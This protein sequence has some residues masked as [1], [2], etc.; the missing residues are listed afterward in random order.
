[1]FFSLMILVVIP[2]FL[3]AFCATAIVHIF[4]MIPYVPSE[5]KV[6][7]KMVQ[8]AR[9]KKNDKVFDLGCGDG[10]LLITAEKKAG[11]QAI[12]FE[13]APLMYLLSKL[14]VLFSRSR[15]QV[16]F[17]SLF[18]APLKSAD[19]I[20]CYLF[21]NAMPR[22][23][24]KIKRECKKGTRVISNTFHIPGLKLIRT[25]KKNAQR[26]MPTIYVYEI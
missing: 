14:R 3:L 1:M 13:I 25:I 4:F 18:S 15:A 21:P 26:G 12:G 19:V 22:L 11:A 16:K 17:Q 10:R 5:Q 20:F 24:A 2:L 7:L 6:V 23:A 9:I 8:L